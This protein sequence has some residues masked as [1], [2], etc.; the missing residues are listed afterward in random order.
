MA[1]CKEGHPAPSRPVASMFASAFLSMPE[2]NHGPGGLIVSSFKRVASS[3]HIVQQ[4][5]SL[6]ADHV[7][8]HRQD[9]SRLRLA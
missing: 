6:R 7:V 9:C 1:G 3:E 2:A 5:Y 8:N 4:L